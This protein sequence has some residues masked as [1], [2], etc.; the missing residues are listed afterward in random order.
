MSWRTRKIRIV[1]QSN[2]PRTKIRKSRATTPSPTTCN[3][4]CI[5]KARNDGWSVWTTYSSWPR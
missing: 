4:F 5:R 2:P 1:H 3:T